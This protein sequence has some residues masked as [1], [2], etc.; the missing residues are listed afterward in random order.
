MKRIV[1]LLL[2]VAVLGIF[3]SP[4]FDIPESAMRAKGLA[5]LIVSALVAVAAF[6]AGFVPRTA[7]V[8][9]LL[10]RDDCAPAAAPSTLLT[11]P[12]LC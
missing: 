12:L 10:S 6:F 2:F 7:V 11:L 1:A 4:A 3:V 9:G 8:L 5:Q